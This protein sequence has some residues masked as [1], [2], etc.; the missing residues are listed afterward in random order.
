MLGAATYD[1][2]FVYHGISEDNPKIM[3]VVHQFSWLLSFSTV[4]S[5]GI[6]EKL[7][8]CS[9]QSARTIYLI[10]GGLK[11]KQSDIYSLTEFMQNNESY[12]W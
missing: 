5:N 10:G 1:I 6:Q 3:T 7:Y 11:E 9:L 8:F 4:L 12:I 2:L